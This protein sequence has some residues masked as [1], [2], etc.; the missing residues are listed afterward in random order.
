MMAATLIKMPAGAWPFV[1]IAASNI[2][3]LRAR[4]LT[5]QLLQLCTFHFHLS[6]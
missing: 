3:M 6:F 1:I 5:D 4:V 2:L